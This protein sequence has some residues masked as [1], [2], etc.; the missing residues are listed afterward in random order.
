MAHWPGPRPEPSR[1]ESTVAVSLQF[2]GRVRGL[3]RLLLGRRGLGGSVVRHRLEVLSVLAAAAELRSAR[4]D[5]CDAARDPATGAFNPAYLGAFLTHAL[6]RAR[7]RFEAL[8]VLCIEIGP[9]TAWRDPR[10]EE[11]V[12]AA[13]SRAVRAMSATLRISDII[14]R[15]DHDRLVAVLPGCNADD[16]LRLARMLQQTIAEAVQAGGIDPA[17]GVTIGLASYPDHALE[18]GPLLAASSEALARA[19]GPDRVASAPSLRPSPTRSLILH[20]VG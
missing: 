16:G 12:D 20:R 3:L 17:P 10:G 1:S 4:L 13:L 19:Q 14:A 5:E 8:S 15:Q 18:A 2:D 9:L 7:R 6:A 11:L